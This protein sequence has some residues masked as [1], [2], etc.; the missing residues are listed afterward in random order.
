MT[1]SLLVYSYQ[2]GVLGI[3][4]FYFCSHF[5]SCHILLTFNHYNQT[6][7]NTTFEGLGKH[8]KACS[9]YS[10]AL[11]IDPKNANAAHNR[12]ASHEKAGRLEEAVRDFCMEI[13]LT[14]P[15]V[16][17]S[18]STPPS[19]VTRSLQRFIRKDIF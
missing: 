19:H 11:D 9:D 10:L 14:F 15:I 18:L 6:I 17:K 3:A 13:D 4:A 1:V 8:D 2:N 16:S 12:A 5:P 7:L